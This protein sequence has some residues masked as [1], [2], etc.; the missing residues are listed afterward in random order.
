LS[1]SPLRQRRRGNRREGRRRL[2]R[3]QGCTTRYPRL[4]D[5]SRWVNRATTAARG[6][7][8]RLAHPKTPRV[9]VG[10]RSVSATLSY[11]SRLLVTECNLPGC[12]PR[13]V[14]SPSGGARP[15]TRSA[16][17]RFRNPAHQS[18]AGARALPPHTLLTQP[19][20]RPVVRRGRR[21]GLPPRAPVDRRL[22]IALVR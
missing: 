5:P 22:H 1:P 6:A 10:R 19:Q 21:L 3:D 13:A 15:A 4:Q 2:R 8:R 11:S 14:H 16:P 20:H 7:V 17:P 18:P 9:T 12:P